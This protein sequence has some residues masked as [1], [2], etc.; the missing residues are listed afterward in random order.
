MQRHRIIALFSVVILTCCL[1]VALAATINLPKT[2]QTTCYGAGGNIISCANTGQDGD[3]QAGVPWPNPRFTDNNNGTVTDNLTG[4]IWLKNA[5]CCDFVGFSGTG[6]VWTDALNV[7]NGLASGNCG[8]TDGSQAG[9]WRLPNVNELESLLDIKNYSPALPT[10]H[11]FTGV[12]LSLYW[13]STTYPRIYALL[14]DLD[15]GSISIA[16]NSD[17]YYYGWPVRDVQIGSLAPSIISFTPTSG[18]TGTS[19][20]IT[21]T[22]FTG[23]TAVSFG[24]TAAQSL[25][26]NSATQI[27]AV[28]GTGTTGTISVTTPGGTATS[29]GTFTYTNATPKTTYDFIWSGTGGSTS[30]WTL[31]SSNIPTTGCIIYGPYAGWTPVSYSYNQSDGTRTLLWAGTGGSASIWNLNS[32]NIMTTFTMY[33]PFSGW[34]PV[35]YSYHPSDG[36][37]TLLWAGTGGSA[38]IWT[39]S[40][41]NIPITGYT[42]YGP[43][44][45]WTPVSYSYNPSD[46]TRTL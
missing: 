16:Y 34:T 37:K 40:S 9:D 19:V 5:H 44:A 1:P 8:L 42:I 20:T 30:I 38:S 24:I 27:T 46:G 25:T 36:T 23:A 22:N 43:Y 41:S 10:G 32:S 31:N 7:A 12:Q 2:G 17:R 26:V 35:N 3:K 15:K 14:V 13:S 29:S 18:R 11:P 33:G 21:G 45:G 6:L 28:L 39:L 4:L